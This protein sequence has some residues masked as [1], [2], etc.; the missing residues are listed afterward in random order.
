MKKTLAIIAAFVMTTSIA[1]A[2]S[3]DWAAKSIKF[4]STNLKNSQDVTGY[5]IYLG[6]G[7]EL[8]SSYNLTADSTASSIIGSIGTDT[9]SSKSTPNALGKL[10]GTY[11]FDYGTKANGDT[12]AMLLSYKDG[13]KMYYNLSS[14]VVTLSGIVDETSDLEAMDFTNGFSYASKGESK[15]I[16]AGGGWVQAVPE[17]STAMLALAGLALL[18]K[19]RRA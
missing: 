19:R 12:F 5:L 7:G 9:G 4:D 14:T 8:S 16:S 10:T 6:S 18:I 3:F 17:P 13:D 2:L 15:T 11:V 1:S